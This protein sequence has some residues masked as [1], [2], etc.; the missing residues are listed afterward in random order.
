MKKLGFGCMR[1]PK[2]DAGIDIEQTCDMI[3]LFLQNGFTY[4]DTARGYLG[5][6]SEGILKTC[7]TE[8]YPR[9]R[10]AL[11]DKLTKSYFSC[12]ADI[13]PF[14][15]KQL[16]ACGV[17]YFD[18]YLM[19]AQNADNYDYFKAHRAYETAFAL[20]SE[21]KIHHVGISFHDKADVLDRILTE[22]PD[23]EVVQ[24]QF[25]YADYDDPAIESRKC[26]EVCRK[27]GKP[28]I[29]MEPVKG[30]SLADLP[31]EARACFDALGPASPAS[32]AL[33]FAAGFEGVA[34]VLSGMSSLSQVQDNI[35][36]MK[37]FRPLSAPE[38]EAV[39]QVQRILAQSDRIGCTACRYC[40]PECPQHIP[41]PEIFALMNAQERYHDWNAGFYYNDAL[42]KRGGKASTCLQC[43]ACERA[44]PQHLGIRELL[45]DA[46]RT[47][48]KN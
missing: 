48:E 28:V 17:T 8:R 23:I 30:G 4:F 2:T 26:Y 27:H 20:K 34:L 36:F 19:H 46:A 38:R 11:A 29:V 18:V 42:T 40:M 47:F 43:G 44:C 33:R 10:Y 25:N 14:F 39:A 31:E 1:F 16:K 3:D 45:K 22:Y 12:E 37:D 6:Q 41:I 5:E 15:E 21:G 7:L 32:Y 24:I 35:S 13:R 9:E